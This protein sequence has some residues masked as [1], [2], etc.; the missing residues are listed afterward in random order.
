MKVKITNIIIATILLL[1]VNIKADEK[2]ETVE[3]GEIYY[4]KL[5]TS[6]SSIF[7]DRNRNAAGPKFFNFA[8]K[9]SLIIDDF[10]EYNKLYCAVS[11]SLIDPGETPDLVKIYEEETNRLICGEYYKCCLPCSCD[12]MK[13]AKV[14]KITREFKEGN[15]VVYALVID[16]PC[17]KNDFPK[18]VNKNYFCRGNQLD[19]E[20][21][22]IQDGKL[23][24][25]MLHEA[26]YCEPSDLRK[27][28]ANKITGRFCPYRNSTPIDELKSG[29]GDVFIKL[30]R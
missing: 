22:E 2:V 25:G 29:M 14:K 3:I 21:V 8:L 1:S 28:Y 12:L 5:L 9:Q 19:D 17:I 13:Y 4:E 24:I 6:S 7:P 11:G 26:K 20:Q 23:I 16:N 10:I 27:I 30:A 15:K 18:K